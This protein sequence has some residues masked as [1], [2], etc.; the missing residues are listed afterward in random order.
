MRKFVHVL[1]MVCLLSVTLPTFSAFATQDNSVPFTGTDGTPV[2]I[3]HQETGNVSEARIS[4]IIAQAKEAIQ[5]ERLEKGHL[6]VTNAAKESTY[7]YFFIDDGVTYLYEESPGSNPELVILDSPQQEQS[8]SAVTDAVYNSE[9][10]TMADFI[11]DGVGGRQRILQNGQY[12]SAR[13]QLPYDYQVDPKGGAFNYGGFAYHSSANGGVGSWVGD[14]GLQY[15]T[16]VGPND[17]MKGWKPV[18]ILKKKVYPEPNGWVQYSTVFDPSYQEATYKNAY[19]SASNVTLYVWYNYNGKVRLKI[20]GTTICR[21][22]KCDYSSPSHT[23]SIIE[24]NASWNIN[25]FSYWKL[26]S[27]VIS[28]DNKGKNKGVFTNIQVDGRTVSGS[29]YAPPEEDHAKITRSGD[30]LTIDVD[31]SRYTN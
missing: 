17:T 21:D 28:S 29:S 31:S 14:M 15:D 11:S 22:R 13:L 10:E 3:R 18:V 2:E 30:T 24:S 16:T 25:Q 12:L 9:Y 8:S 7:D 6:E 19:K 4:A 1:T 23:I 20:D 5:Q 26:L 27:T